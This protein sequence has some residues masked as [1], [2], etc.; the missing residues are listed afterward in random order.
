MAHRKTIA[1][2]LRSD[3]KVFKCRPSENP[4]AK[5]VVVESWVAGR[6]DNIAIRTPLIVDI[7]VY[8]R[9]RMP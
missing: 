8:K 3:T 1:D 4:N 6:P 2:R 9:D 5:H 7:A